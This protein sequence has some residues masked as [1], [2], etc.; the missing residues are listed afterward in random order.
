MPYRK[1]ATRYIKKGAR[2]GMRAGKQ[3]VKANRGALKAGAG[4]AIRKGVWHRSV[5]KGGLQ[6]L[7]NIGKIAAGYDPTKGKSTAK[8]LRGLGGKALR[9][10]LR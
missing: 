4:H 2:K 7:K 8:I 5:K 10:A 6:A 9:R 3:W 1:I